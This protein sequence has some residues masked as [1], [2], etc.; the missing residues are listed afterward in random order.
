MRMMHVQMEM[1]DYKEKQKRYEEF[2]ISKI[3][4][5]KKTK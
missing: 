1:I 4:K 5:V 3:Q 2:R